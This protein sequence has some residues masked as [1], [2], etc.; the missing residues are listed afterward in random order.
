MTVTSSARAAWD[1]QEAEGDRAASRRM[2]L[3][4]AA[5]LTT[6]LDLVNPVAVIRNAEPVRAWLLGGPDT[7]RDRM[8]RRRAARLHLGNLKAALGSSGIP[9]YVTGPEEFI[10]G[11]EQYYQQIVAGQYG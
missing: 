4:I 10:D 11:A 2:A 8:Y 3:E 7:G 1:E 9:A 6:V 5:E